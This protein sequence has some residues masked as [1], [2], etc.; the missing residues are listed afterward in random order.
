MG[1]HNNKGDPY[2]TTQQDRTDEKYRAKIKNTSN[3]LLPN[4]GLFGVYW[5]FDHCIFFSRLF[6]ARYT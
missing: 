1:A 5:H 2:N 3:N 4:L 6:F